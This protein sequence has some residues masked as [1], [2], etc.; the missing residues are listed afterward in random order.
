MN[1]I[2][3]L[4]EVLD[5]VGIPLLGVLPEDLQIKTAFSN[6]EELVK[7]SI[8]EIVFDRIVARIEGEYTP[9]YIE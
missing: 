8:P 4:D 2:S 5:G 7:G 9:L 3:D 1:I 6:G